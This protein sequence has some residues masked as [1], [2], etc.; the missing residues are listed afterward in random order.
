M[1]RINDFALYEL[2]GALKKLSNY[3]DTIS[4]SDVWFEAQAAVLALDRLLVG[5]PINIEF[6]KPSAQVLKKF[7]VKEFINN[8]DGEIFNAIFPPKEEEEEVWG[9]TFSKYRELLLDFET[10]FGTEMRD[11]ATYFVPRRGIYHTPSLIDRADDAIPEEI[12]DYVPKKSKE[13]WKSAGRFL[14]FNLH[15]ASGFHVTRAVEGTL[16]HYYQ[17]FCQEDSGTTLNGW[18]D[19]IVKLKGVTSNP[20][21]SSKTL[22]ELEQ[23]KDD[24]RNP[25]AHPRVILSETDARMLFDNG[26]ALILGMASEI[27]DKEG[28]PQ[29]EGA[30]TVA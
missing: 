28:T 4:K 23:M 21:P 3:N 30:T 6:S 7:L 8:K 19:Y 5:F 20:K 10:V 25:L 27:K 2:A 13:D 11:A 29:N 12:R 24:F 1:E 22:A 15:S 14:A 16:E 17:F 26:E 9:F 18:S